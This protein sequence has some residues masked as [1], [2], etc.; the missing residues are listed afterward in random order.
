MFGWQRKGLLVLAD[1]EGKGNGCL[2]NLFRLDVDL[3]RCFSICCGVSDDQS[4]TFTA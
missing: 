2:C 4:R 3:T 1:L